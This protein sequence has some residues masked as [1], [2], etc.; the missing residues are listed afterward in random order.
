MADI[1]FFDWHPPSLCFVP[2]LCHASGSE[3]ERLER[4]ELDLGEL[5][6]PSGELAL[7]CVPVV[8]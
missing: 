4:V 6:I 3:A 1:S 2:G 5:S 7:N 8:L